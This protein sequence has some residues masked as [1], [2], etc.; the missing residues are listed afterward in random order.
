M[1]IPFPNFCKRRRTHDARLQIMF[2]DTSRQ[3]LPQDFYWGEESPVASSLRCTNLFQCSSI[4]KKGRECEKTIENSNELIS[5]RHCMKKNVRF[6]T[7]E[8]RQ[9]AITL[10]DNPNCSY[11]LCLDWGHTNSLHL[12]VNDYAMNSSSNTLP[13]KVEERLERLQAMGFQRMDLRVKE[14]D[15]RLKLLREWECEANGK[16][17]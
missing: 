3:E 12:F 7:V 6:T 17:G 10:G 5:M 15:R 14:R 16:S 11:P 2:T 8:V 1:T 9:Y 4:E 13:L